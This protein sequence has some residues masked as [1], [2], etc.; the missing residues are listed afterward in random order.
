LIG[1]SEM[2]ISHLAQ[3]KGANVAG[4][5][6][7]S[8]AAG[9]DFEDLDVFYLAGGFAR[10]IDLDAAR[11]I[12]LIPNLPDSRIRKIGNASIAGA[13]AALLSAPLR[14]ELEAFARRAV[15]VELETSSEFF[16][17]FVDGC[18]FQPVRSIGAEAGRR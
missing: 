7:L 4:L 16:D 2:D 13:T 1:L 11:R 10:H 17:S 18:Q 15:H 14:R 3:A 12:G 8:R 9:I 6:I 5:R